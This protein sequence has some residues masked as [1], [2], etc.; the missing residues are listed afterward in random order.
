MKLGIRHMS[1][2]PY[3]CES[4][5]KIEKFNGYADSFLAELSLEPAKTLDDLNR[6]WKV[7]LDDEYNHKPHASLNGKTPVEAY[8]Q[9]TK[10]V[11]MAHVEDLYDGFVHETMC[12]VDK[13]GCLKLHSIEFEAGIAFCG[14][15][16]KVH[17]D[18]FDLSEVRLYVND[19]FKGNLKPLVTREFC[20]TKK[21]TESVKKAG[22]SRMFA[23]CEKHHDKRKVISTGAIAF[24]HMGDKQN[25]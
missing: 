3:C 20:G 16:V 19:E 5:G 17:F 4:K 13:T 2:R 22:Y 10:A 18:P 7:W 24:R 6:K 23:A 12:K 14:Q 21:Q 9:D 15:K 25:V 8:M 11:R 1:A